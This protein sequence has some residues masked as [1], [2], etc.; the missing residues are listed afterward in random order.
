MS[1]NAC[2]WFSLPTLF[3]ALSLAAFILLPAHSQRMD[4]TMQT[5]PAQAKEILG[6]IDLAPVLPAPEELPRFSRYRAAS[7]HTFSPRPDQLSTASADADAIRVDDNLRLSVQVGVTAT[8]AEAQELARRNTDTPGG[9]MPEGSPSGH[10]LGQK[11]WHS[12]YYDGGPPR[13]GYHLVVYDGRAV[14][15][16]QIAAQIHIQDGTPI[17]PLLSQE[18]LRLAEDIASACLTRLGY[19]GFTSQPALSASARKHF[20]TQRIALMHPAKRPPTHT[21]HR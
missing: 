14:V 3:L 13:G 19:L 21:A 7:R 10:P 17:E 2:A 5:S 11:V 1:K 18:D 6:A 20:L 16:V 8:P 15:F 12:K 4:N 9:Q